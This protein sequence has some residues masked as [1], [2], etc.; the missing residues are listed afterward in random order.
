[1]G[2]GGFIVGRP[3]EEA[4][5]RTQPQRRRDTTEAHRG[6]LDDT[7]TNTRACGFIIKDDFAAGVC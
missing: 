5:A 1:M 4:G 3:R 7:H 6:T 2:A